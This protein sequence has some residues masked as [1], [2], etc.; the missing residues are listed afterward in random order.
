M[1][2]FY[3]EEELQELG[4]KSCGKNVLISRKSS[5]YGA[6]NITI[7]NHVRVDDFCILSGRITLGNHIHV[8]A[9][10][11]LY[12]AKE[13]IE[14]GDYV[15]ISSRT[16]IYAVSDDY[17]G[18]FMTNPTLPEQF[19]GVTNAPVQIGKHT[20]IGASS[21]VLPGVVVGEGASF[22]AFSLIKENC[23]G[24]WM[25]AGIPVKRVKERSR[26]LLEK[27]EEFEQKMDKRG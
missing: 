23:E 12:G 6:E 19:R 27:A 16:S 17:S 8:S 1:S 7:G 20:I 10:A 13:G 14:V 11:A 5:I 21:V 22:G 25:Y 4:L 24:W 9:Y 26:G 2:S 3:S 15:S 18:E